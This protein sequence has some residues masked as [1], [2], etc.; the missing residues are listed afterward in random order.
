VQHNT[1]FDGFHRAAL[2]AILD[3]NQAS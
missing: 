1:P 3:S 2:P